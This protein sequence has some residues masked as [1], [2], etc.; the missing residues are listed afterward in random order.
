MFI[1]D[2]ILTNIDDF[3]VSATLYEV[4][5]PK[6]LVQIIHGAL[7]HKGRYKYFISFLNEN[8]YAVII[9]DNR[10]AWFISE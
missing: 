10:G 3:Q 8:G 1:K 9:S 7:E 4:E 5:E 2:L 6:A